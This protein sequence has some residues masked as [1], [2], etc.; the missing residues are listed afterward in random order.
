ML[1][2]EKLVYNFLK[3]RQERRITLSIRT[4]VKPSE[5]IVKRFGAPVDV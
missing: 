1:L 2:Q 5:L 4:K 3:G